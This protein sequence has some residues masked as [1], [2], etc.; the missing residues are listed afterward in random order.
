MLAPRKKIYGKPGE[1]NKKQ[2]HDFANKS[3]SSQSYVFFFFSVVMYG[4]K[5]GAIKKAER[6]KID[7]FDT[8]LVLERMLESSFDCKEIKP[9]H[10]KG[11]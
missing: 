3:P 10:P 11:N 4:Y 9:V 8:S 7:S 1:H 5:S 6:Q 2:R